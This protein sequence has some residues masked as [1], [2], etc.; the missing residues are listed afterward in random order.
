MSVVDVL[1]TACLLAS[2]PSVVASASPSP[3]AARR[4]AQIALLVDDP[5]R[6]YSIL[7]I[8]HHDLHCMYEEHMNCFWTPN[9][10]DLSGDAEDLK[11]GKVTAN[12]RHFLK[13]VLSFFAGSDVIVA[14]N[15]QRFMMEVKLPEARLFYGFQVMM[16][17]IHSEIY[18]RMVE[19]VCPSLQEQDEVNQAVYNTPSVRGKAQWAEKYMDPDLPFAQRVVAFAIVEGVFFSA[20]FCSIFWFKQRGKL[21]GGF[22]KSNEFIARDEGLH[23][24]FAVHLYKHH[25]P[26][27]HQLDHRQLKEM[28]EAAFALECD[29][30]KDAI[31]VQLLGMNEETMAT[32]VQFVIDYWL[33]QLGAPKLYGV[34]NPFDWMEISSLEGKT[35]FFEQRVSEYS[36]ANMQRPTVLDFGGDDS[37]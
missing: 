6:R 22:C 36:M 15:M 26:T 30:I 4:V 13:R 23:T 24:R 33:Q 2:Q 20:A 9:E 17:N 10:I 12:E 7:P 14:E 5:K 32:Y 21:L 16:E 8:Q 18:G 34:A 28:F 19:M 37:F 11:T 27:E 29:F 3:P 1:P 35:N 31:P 25:I